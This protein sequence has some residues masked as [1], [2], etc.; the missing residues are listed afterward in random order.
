MAINITLPDISTTFKRYDFDK[1]KSTL[2]RKAGL[3]LLYDI[4]NDL[5]YVGK[6]KNL[7][8][9]LHQHFR[10]VSNAE[11]FFRLIDSVKVYFVDDQLEREL[12]ETYIINEFKPTMNI[13]KVY[14]EGTSLHYE[15]EEYNDHIFAVE[16]EIREVYDE[17]EELYD[18][19]DR[20]I[21]DDNSEELGEELLLIDRLRKLKAKKSQLIKE[22]S[23]LLNKINM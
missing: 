19:D 2:K 4:N 5:L 10:G 20:T 11:R 21:N 16:E 22:R 1:Y 6:T 8:N 9:R 13:S 7:L 17:L 15:L 12:Y 23:V 14:Y 3:Y 18:E